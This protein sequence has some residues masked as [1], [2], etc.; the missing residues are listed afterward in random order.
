MY[1]FSICDCTINR[2]S[3]VKEVWVVGWCSLKS[4]LGIWGTVN[5]R[6][7]VDKDNL[8]LGLD[9]Q[10]DEHTLKCGH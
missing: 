9:D 8:G 5:V 10:I 6:S 4:K 2:P 1:A 3:I 7:R